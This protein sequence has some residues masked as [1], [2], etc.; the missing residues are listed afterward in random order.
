[1]HRM[2]PKSNFKI[3]N[4]SDSSRIYCWICTH[5]I[6]RGQK[7]WHLWWFEERKASLCLLR[8]SCRVSALMISTA[9]KCKSIPL[10]IDCGILESLIRYLI[11]EVSRSTYMYIFF[12][13][14]RYQDRPLHLPEAHKA[15]HE[16]HI[17]GTVGAHQCAESCIAWMVLP[18]YLHKVRWDRSVIAL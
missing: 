18:I 6:T 3:T 14:C 17:I 13:L 5:W 4:L 7:N 8:A 12:N 15:T 10:H 9:I 11:S 1:M 16:V 2:G